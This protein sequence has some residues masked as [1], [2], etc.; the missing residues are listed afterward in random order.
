MSI[1]RRFP[2]W[3]NAV[4]VV[5]SVMACVALALL[6][7]VRLTPATWDGIADRLWDFRLTA[8]EGAAVLVVVAL[9]VVAGAARARWS[10]RGPVTIHDV[11]DATG[12]EGPLALQITAILRDRMARAGVQ[13]RGVVP[14]YSGVDVGGSDLVSSSPVNASGLI[15]KVFFSLLQFSTSSP[16][17][18]VDATIRRSERGESGL[19]VVVQHVAT[20]RH[21]LVQTVWDETPQRPARRAAYVVAA[22]HL[23]RHAPPSSRRRPTWRPSADAL[24]H[25]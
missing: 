21:D 9:I 24:R 22:W 3:F 19:T 2:R 1:G 11:T 7:L 4:L 14:S 12:A 13:P 15:T 18:R 8:K 10:T 25:Y 17:W 16:G 20:G 6:V 23:G 5:L